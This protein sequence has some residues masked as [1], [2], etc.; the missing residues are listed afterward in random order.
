MIKQPVFFITASSPWGELWLCTT[1]RGICYLS[2]GATDGAFSFLARQGIEKPQAGE[3]PWLTA[4]QEQLAAYFAGSER[5]FGLP[6]DL[7][8]TPF[9]RAVWIALLQIPYGETR[10]YGEIAAAVG[11]PAAA[12]AVG[13]AV[14]ANPVSIIVPCHRVLGAGG[15]LTG[16]GGGLQRKRG[17]LQLEHAAFQGEMLFGDANSLTAN[18]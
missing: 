10:T 1:E 9:Q 4:A 17:L 2:F 13:Q 12:R 11:R 6:L 14:G 15:T 16:Y 18:R 7:R 8:G 5:E 3:R